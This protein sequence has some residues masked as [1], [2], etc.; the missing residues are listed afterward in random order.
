MPD[1]VL[2]VVGSLAYAA[3]AEYAHR[4][5]FREYGK[6]TGPL[7]RALH[8][9]LRRRHL[10]YVVSRLAIAAASVA[11]VGVLT[12]RL[13]LWNRPLA[14]AAILWIASFFSY[15]VSG[16]A[17]WGLGFYPVSGGFRTRYIV[18]AIPAWQFLIDVALAIPILGFAWGIL[19]LPALG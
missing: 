16:A 4:R 11:A 3:L 7:L 5:I 2:L 8:P 17:G 10:I 15:V 18:A 19:S 13:G 6:L 9:Q 12:I 1:T 14:S